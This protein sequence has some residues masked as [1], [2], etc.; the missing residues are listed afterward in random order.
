[1]VEMAS[2]EAMLEPIFSLWTAQQQDETR[3]LRVEISELTQL[4]SIREAQGGDRGGGS[5]EAVPHPL[6]RGV[7]TGPGELRGDLASFQQANSRLKVS[8]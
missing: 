2:L 6:A 7:R 5:R 3:A 4:L 1:M 8:A